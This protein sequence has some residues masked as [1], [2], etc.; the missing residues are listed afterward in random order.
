MS[1][2]AHDVGHGLS[3][4]LRLW[5]RMQEAACMK[6]CRYTACRVIRNV[7]ILESRNVRARSIKV[8]SLANTNLDVVQEV[9]FSHFFFK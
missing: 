7:W 1:P 3:Q 4:A 9:D 8:V 6:Y 5:F 2:F